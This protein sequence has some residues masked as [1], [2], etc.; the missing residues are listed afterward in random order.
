MLLKVL[1]EGE[2]K[3]EISLRERAHPVGY[4]LLVGCVLRYIIQ[5]RMNFETPILR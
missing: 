4:A 1:S 5:S 3:L 2:K